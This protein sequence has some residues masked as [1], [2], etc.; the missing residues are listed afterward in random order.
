MGAD[1][2]ENLEFFFILALVTK[3]SVV[4]HG[5]FFLSLFFLDGIVPTL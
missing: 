1:G 4:A 3:L 5:P 2:D